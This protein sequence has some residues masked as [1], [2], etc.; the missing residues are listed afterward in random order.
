VVDADELSRRAVEPGSTALKKVAAQ[1]GS[2]V[3]APDGTLDRAALRNVVFN[4]DA[5]RRQLESIL[6]PEIERLRQ[7]EERAAAGK[8]A[9]IVVH[10]IPLLFETGL[11]EL[12]DV[13]VVVDA[14]ES[15]RRD[16]LVA[17]RGLAA[18]EAEAMIRAQMSAGI[19]R[20]RAHHIIEN[21]G[22]LEEL[23]GRAFDVWKAI[24]ERAA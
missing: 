2:D 21:T 14:P 16:R 5:R 23:R 12:F 1:F 18:A 20:S 9:R 7:E 19:K 10:A 13:I 17:T 24:Q 4:D 3:V 8:G 15:V 6:H 11:D 22:S